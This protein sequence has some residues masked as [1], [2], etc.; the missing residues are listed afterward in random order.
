MIPTD[1]QMLLDDV[2]WEQVADRVVDVGEVKV[3]RRTIDDLWCLRAQGSSKATPD[4]LLDTVWD[5]ARVPSWSSNALTVSDV[6]WTGPSEQVFW[7]ALDL[8]FPM[9]DRLWVL[10]ATAVHDGDARAMRWNR[11]PASAWPAVQPGDA[12]EMPVSWGEWAFAPASGGGSVV[13]W[14]GCQD[15]GGAVPAWLQTWGATRSLPS[16][17]SDLVHA[18][19]R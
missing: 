19:E 13:E 5:V 12:M 2:G 16:A 17:V 3:W 11:E 1:W 14:R 15:I 9:S 18:A 10:R 8:P 7:Q 6:L 4:H